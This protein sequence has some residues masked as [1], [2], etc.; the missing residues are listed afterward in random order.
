MSGDIDKADEEPFFARWS[1]RKQQA[2]PVALR[3]DEPGEMVASAQPVE[4][5]VAVQQKPTTHVATESSERI[6]KKPLTEDDFKDVDFSALD[7]GSDYDRFMQEGVPEGIR[8]KALTKL[9]HSD[10]IFTQVDPFQDYAGD[11]T[12]AA[13]VPL[14]GVVR[15]AYKVGQG[16]LSDAEAHEWHRLGKPPLAVEIAAMPVLVPGYRVRSATA[17]DGAALLAV[18]RAAILQA[19]GAVHGAELA[20][21]WASGLTPEGYGRAITKGEA[22]EIALNEETGEAVAFSSTKN[23]TIEALFVHARFGRKGLGRALLARAVEVIRIAGHTRVHL[24]ADTAARAFYEAQGFAVVASRTMASR[25]GLPME[26]LDMQKLLIAP[27]DVLI[28]RESP[29]QPDVHAF[30]AASEAYAS[31]LYPAESNHFVDV[32]TLVQPNVVFLVARGA[33]RALG[34][35]AIVKADDGTAEIKRMWVAPEARGLKLGQRLLDALIEAARADGVS[36][37]Q[38]ETGIS[39]PEALGLY[40]RAGFVEIGPFRDYQPDSLSVFMERPLQA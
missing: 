16:F 3:Q 17:E 15:T 4:A 25:G 9:W 38:L 31:A 40:R 29:D 37:L 21:S 19:A 20:E 8:Q 5:D 12:D 22:I 18:H 30:L 1:R 23:D 26:A 39:Q 11:Y 7:Y 35:G 14:G 32:A 13:V 10:P 2:K 6:K 33:G 36:K 28:T 34:C 24:K 27:S